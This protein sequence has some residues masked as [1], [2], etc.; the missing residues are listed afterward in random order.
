MKKG[1]NVLLA[2]SLTLNGLLL[3]FIKNE[4]TV[5]FNDSHFWSDW[6]METSGI[7]IFNDKELQP[8]VTKFVQHYEFSCLEKSCVVVESTLSGNSIV[9]FVRWPDIV[10]LNYSSKEAVFKYNGCQ[11]SVSKDSTTFICPGN[12]IG[13]L[14]SHINLFHSR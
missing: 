4:T 13:T 6:S 12:K 8:D 9:N 1:T 5:F 10:S 3:Y 14:G 2:I 7:T 11:F